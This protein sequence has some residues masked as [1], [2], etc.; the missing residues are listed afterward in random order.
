[1]RVVPF[2]YLSHERPGLSL[3]KVTG[4][5]GKTRVLKVSRERPGGFQEFFEFGAESFDVLAVNAVDTEL[6][7]VPEFFRRHARDVLMGPAV[8]ENDPKM[9]IM[10]M[11]QPEAKE[12]T[13]VIS[14]SKRR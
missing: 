2:L 14:Y 1:M 9:V 13:F 5:D 7:D 6:W 11:P 3:Q 8:N 12:A 4:D 10:R